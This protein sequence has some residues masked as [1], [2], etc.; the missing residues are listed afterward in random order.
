V[1]V[2]PE[3]AAVRRLA[4][5]PGSFNP[6]T[7][8]HEALAEAA[9]RSGRVDAVYYLL[10]TRTVNK[11]RIEGASLPDRLICLE[12]IA[13]AGERVGVGLINRGLYVDQ[14]ATAR[15]AMPDLDEL[16]FV[17]G[18][19]KIVQI[20]DPRYYADLHRALVQLFDRARFLVA[21]RA[22]SGP[23][24]LFELLD[25]PEHRQFAERVVP[26]DLPPAYRDDASSRVRA[27][28]AQEEAPD[29]RVFA[30]VPPI[31][32]ELV[33]VTGAYV[34]PRHL[35]DGEEV[36]RYAWRDRA[37]D[38]VEAGVVPVLDPARFAAL[39][40]L[41]TAPDA[42]GRQAREA[43]GRDDG[44]RLLAMLGEGSPR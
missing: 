4:L 27:S 12:T 30:E 40:D 38:L 34:R 43:A 18:F 22:D 5:L 32:A 7:R 31:V 13:R 20:F 3:G 6:P 29:E 26:L 35:P 14:A 42:R 11:E 10:A 8:A 44:T 17:V 15:A 19:D 23:E 28:L 25:R 33:R 21:P 2:E 1:L 37:I 36:D 9:W 16:W 24:D 39:V 41:L